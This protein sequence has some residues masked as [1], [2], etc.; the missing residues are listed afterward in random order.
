MKKN[1]NILVFDL[2]STH[3]KAC[4]LSSD[5]DIVFEAH[6]DNIRTPTKYYEAL[7]VQN[8]EVFIFENLKKTV[9]DYDI[10]DIIVS[11][12]G[13]SLALIKESKD[14]F[15][16]FD[17]ALALPVMFYG[18]EVPKDIY[19]QYEEQAPSFSETFAEISP[20]AL[21]GALQLFWQ[22]QTWPEEFGK[23]AKILM[24]PSYWSFRLSGACYNDYSSLGAQNQIWNPKSKDFSSFVKNQ[25]WQ[26]LFAQPTESSKKIGV[27][28]PEI[29]K[30]YHFKNQPNILC[31]VHDSNANYWRFIQMGFDKA[32]IMSTGTWIVNF[33]PLMAPENL[34]GKADCCSNVSAAGDILSCSR[35][36]GG[37]ELS[38]LLKQMGDIPIDTQ[39]SAE[40]LKSVLQNDCLICPSFAS[41]GGPVRHANGKGRI[42]GDLP[43]DDH[44]KYA[45][46]IVYLAFMTQ[47][48]LD[49]IDGG[50]ELI[51]DGPF[52]KN[53]LFLQL[54]ALLNPLS[55]IY[56]SGEINGTL[57]G[58][59][60]LSHQ[61]EK[62]LTHKKLQKISI[63]P[64]YA[65]LKESLYKY[66]KIWLKKSV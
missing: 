51:I 7:D 24:W 49:Y 5:F 54:I 62:P 8:I 59:A 20:L 53:T 64:E 26:H 40:D 17:D 14:A 60:S 43:T 45:L 28:H 57:W 6:K 32:T 34:Q 38:I 30:K 25:D 23:V 29:C 3:L 19:E 18:Q 21:T 46:A 63:L 16:P 55:D 31:G 9:D 44:Q 48:S 47:L 66:K 41:S 61:V 13:S 12:H 58:A 39:V 2:G 27:L 15:N 10:G 33:N 22:S 11:T 36:Q 35:Y 37:L 4:V 52:T 50:D 65:D 56:I 42:I 1:K